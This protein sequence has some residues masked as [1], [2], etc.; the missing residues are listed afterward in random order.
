M[1]RYLIDCGEATSVN[2]FRRQNVILLLL[3]NIFIFRN[4]RT[5]DMS[6]PVYIRRFFIGHRRDEAIRICRTVEY[7]FVCF[8]SVCGSVPLRSLRDRAATGGARTHEC[9][10]VRRFFQTTIRRRNAEN[11]TNVLRPS[12]LTYDCYPSQLPRPR[13]INR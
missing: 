12:P 4:I 9:R 2:T 13:A 11:R 3:H 8:K 6:S 10:F 1:N 5:R 7:F